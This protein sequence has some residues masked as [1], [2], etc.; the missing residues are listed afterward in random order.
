[1]T[2]TA[3][4]R[5]GLL[6]NPS[7]GYGGKAIG[8]PVRN[9]GARVTVSPADEADE[10]VV[11]AGGD[12]VRLRTIHRVDPLPPAPRNG[13]ERLVVAA[14]ARLA[15]SA[16]PPAGSAS[17]HLACT[18]TVPRQVGLAGSSAV[19]IATLRALSTA[20]EIEL[21]PFALAEMALAT[22]VEDLGVAAGPMDR[23]VQAYER[24]MLMDLAP[25]RSETSYRELDPTSLPPILI[26]WDPR[27]GKSSDVTHGDLRSRWERGD[28]AVHEVVAELRAVVDRGVEA[29]AAGD[30]AAFADLMDLNFRL[31]CRITPV[32]TVDRK[33]VG[34]AQANGAAAKLCGSGGSVVIVPRLG[35]HLDKLSSVLEPEGFRTCR[36]ELE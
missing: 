26:A 17:C 13:L 24:T 2:G 8:I 21:S 30:H 20:W 5:A 36:P 25:P 19:I 32:G 7:D 9:F 4:A 33:M 29:L 34:L 3:F 16:H 11:S 28:P 12:P 31:R 6:G 18:T 23:V 27:G 14:A 35:A 10:F 1:L 22:E 15:R